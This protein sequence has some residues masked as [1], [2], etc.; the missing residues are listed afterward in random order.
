M[1]LELL[2][3]VAALAEP[4]RRQAAADAL[5]STLGADALL[6]FIRDAEVELLLPAAG[7]P[8]TLPNGKLWQNFLATCV[9]RGTHEDKLPLG[10]PDEWCPAVGYAEGSDVVAVL[11]GTAK[12][13]VDVSSFRVLLPLL[14]ATFRGERAVALAIT[15]VRQARESADRATVLMTALDRARR[16]LED[17][18]L[19]ARDARAE[20][21]VANGKLMD[22]SAELELVN[23]QLREQAEELEA[24]ATELEQQ[25]DDLQAANAS[26]EEARHV[27]EKANRAKSEF[28]A[29]MSH[30]LRTP[31]NAIGGYVQLIEMGVHGPVTKAQREALER[32][33]RSQRH[34]LGLIND[35]LNLSRIESGRVQY[36]MTDVPLADAVS[37]LAPMIEPQLAA[38][39]L[40]YDV[41]DKESFPVVRADR[42][43]LQQ[44][45]LNLLSNAV[46]FTDPGGRISIASGH[47]DDGS[48]R[49]FVRVNDSGHGIPADKLEAIFEPF[50]QVDSS[51]SRVGHGTGLGLAISRDLARGM[52][53]DLQAQSEPGVGSTFTLTL[54]GDAPSR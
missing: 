1:S 9:T 3:C 36:A 54:S 28:L 34:L 47:C 52:G 14:A 26:L 21:Q 45:L 4:D 15:K 51:H 23:A 41:R 8:Q 2:R 25:A 13:A 16:Q 5:A 32:V 7:F 35:I 12:G 10:A 49:V 38:K 31:L 37:D 20:L 22:H 29:T 11:L 17:A 46:K 19:A 53:G 42:E 18:L 27:A 24:Q 30:E 39:A 6:I 48:G 43:K 40:D 50:I 44:I 33:D